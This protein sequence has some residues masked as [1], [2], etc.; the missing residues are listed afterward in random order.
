MQSSTV[1]ICSL[2]LSN[3]SS[4]NIFEEKKRRK[5]IWEKKEKI[6]KIKNYQNLYV[7]PVYVDT[8]TCILI[9]V[10]CV[11][12]RVVISRVTGNCL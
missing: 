8:S 2:S 7:V 3:E 5:Y 6:F 10:I 1:C 4:N 11:T 12:L 9:K